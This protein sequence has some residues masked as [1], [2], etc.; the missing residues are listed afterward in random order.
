LTNIKKESG[1]IGGILY[2]ECCL[3]SM[4]RMKDDF[5]DLTI[6]SPPY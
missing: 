6:T 4:N 1:V 3:S 5:V 2:N